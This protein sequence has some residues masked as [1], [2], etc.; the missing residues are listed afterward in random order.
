MERLKREADA[1]LQEAQSLAAHLNTSI[2]AFENDCRLIVNENLRNK[3]LQ[4]LSEITSKLLGQ[5][6]SA[7]REIESYPPLYRGKVVWIQAMLTHDGHDFDFSPVYV[8]GVSASDIT[9][10]MEKESHNVRYASTDAFMRRVYS[11]KSLIS[12]GRID[13][14]LELKAKEVLWEAMGHSGKLVPTLDGMTPQKKGI[15]QYG[16]RRVLEPK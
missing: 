1:G 6:D 16:Y 4:D 14:F 5:V 8:V 2:D 7:V 13:N 15:S 9:A 11:L 10:K 12:N 3:M